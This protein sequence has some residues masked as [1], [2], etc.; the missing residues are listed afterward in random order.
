[1]PEIGTGG[2]GREPQMIVGHRLAVTEREQARDRVDSGHGTKQDFDARIAPQHLADGF[3]D[4][5]GRQ[6]GRRDLVEQRLEQMIVAAVDQR[7]G[8]ACG[9]QAARHFDAGKAAADNDDTVT[10]RRGDHHAFPNGLVEG[11]HISLPAAY[12]YD[13]VMT[14]AARIQA[15]IDILTALEKTDLPADRLIRDYFRS[16]RYAGSKDRA[17]I[18]ERVFSILRHRFSLAWRLQDDTPRSLVLASVAAAGEDP[19]LL[20]TGQTYAPPPLSDGE[21]QRL[22]ARQGEPPLNAVG[23]FPPLLET[24]LKPAFC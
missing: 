11:C 14:P 8:D 16:R 15:A 3:G 5:A 21:R 12:L 18:A 20:F 2:A 1:M 6:R 7:C 4:I 17:A 19:D 13:R 22:G 10:G 9:A 24:E 23:E